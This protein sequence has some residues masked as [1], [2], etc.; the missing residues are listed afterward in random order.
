MVHRNGQRE[1]YSVDPELYEAFHALDKESIGQLTKV[2]AFP[3]KMLRTGVT[4]GPEFQA[5]NI[6]SDQITAFINSDYGYFP[7]VDFFRGALHAIKKDDV[8]WETRNLKMSTMASMD[9]A[10]LQKSLNEIL[11]EHKAQSMAKYIIRHPIDAILAVRDFGEQATRYGLAGKALAKETA[12][13]TPS[14]EAIYRAIVEAREGTLNFQRGGAKTKSYRL[15]TA[16]W[17]VN[18]LGMDTLVK[19]FQKAPVRTSTRVFMGITLPSILLWAANHDDERYKEIP[20]WQKNSFWI[21]LPGHVSKEDWEK[22]TAEEQAESLAWNPLKS[23]VYRIPKGHIYGWLFGSSFERL[24]DAAYEKNPKAIKEWAAGFLKSNAPV[25]LPTFALPLIEGWANKSFFRDRPLVPVGMQDLEPK[26]QALPYTSESAKAIGKLLNVSPLKVDN[27]VRGWTGGLGNL[28]NDVINNLVNYAT[29]QPTKPEPTMADKPL[30]R[31]F[32]VRYPSSD[33]KSIQTFYEHLKNIR[34]TKATAK[35]YEKTNRTERLGVYQDDKF[36]DIEAAKDF[37][38]AADLM[39]AH[40]TS[41]RTINADMDLDAKEKRRKIDELT[42]SMI[43][44]A[45]KLNEQYQELAENK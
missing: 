13:G 17:N 40:R 16:F 21:Y 34:T 24:L 38:T 42:F 32:V 37:E 33:S 14:K 35:L 29:T 23:G 27:L 26:E 4:L 44:L 1:F 10:H 41:I 25:G 12:K 31:A 8:Y 2:L 36:A 22:M 39:S 28:T 18:I 20:D 30:L 9:R 5:R 7:F 11:T 6:F 15:M 45:K 19:N 3:A 43:A